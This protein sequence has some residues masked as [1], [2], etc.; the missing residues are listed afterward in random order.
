MSPVA[1]IY[2][3]EQQVYENIISIRGR[4]NFGNARKTKFCLKMFFLSVT[5]YWTVIVHE[6]IMNQYANGSTENVIYWYANIM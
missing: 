1:T 6:N 3:G 2:T 4:G 5:I